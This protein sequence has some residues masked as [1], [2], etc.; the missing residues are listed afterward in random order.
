MSIQLTALDS[1]RSQH[2]L[3][4]TRRPDT[5]PQCHHAIELS[6]QF[7]VSLDESRKIVQV[8]HRCPKL[9]CQSVFIANYALDTSSGRYTYQNTA[10]SKY[11]PRNF[12]DIIHK[13]SLDFCD[14]YNQSSASESQGLLKICGVGYRKALEFLIKDYLIK[15]H[16]DKAEVIKK[17]FLGKCIEEYVSNT[18]I[19]A[20]SKRAVW[21][22][23]DET[24]YV[25]VW[26]GKDL[27]DLKGLVDLTV[28]W[29][30]ME[31]LTSDVMKDMP[32][33]VPPKR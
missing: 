32:D 20:V 8:V 4:I 28:H 27:Q 24:H 5:C 13:V 25:R 9:A 21:L 29:I 30:E 11:V 19:K 26:E 17:Q 2:A 15:Q 18:N 14:I 16:P 23:N 3:S 7:F 12:S 6:D 10:P 31:Q 1:K 33:N 22:G